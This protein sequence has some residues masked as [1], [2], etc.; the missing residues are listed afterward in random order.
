MTH[1]RAALDKELTAP[2]RLSIAAALAAVEDAEFAAVRDAVETN[3]AELSRQ[4]SRL[5]SV[6]Y[7]A[8]SKK[9]AG[10]YARTWLALTPEGRDRLGAHVRALREITG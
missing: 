10:R 9:K 6:G 2:L 1:P 5:E 7:V 8:V 3:D 4:V